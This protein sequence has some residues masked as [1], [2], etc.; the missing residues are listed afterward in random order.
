M[1][2]KIIY[3]ELEQ[4]II[5]FYTGFF[6][7]GSTMNSWNSSYKCRKMQYFSQDGKDGAAVNI[8][9]AGLVEKKTSPGIVVVVYG[10]QT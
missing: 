6:L 2:T 9:Q 5:N 7:F 10:S 4:A 1:S 3:F 8:A